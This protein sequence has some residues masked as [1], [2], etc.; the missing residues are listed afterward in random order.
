MTWSCG[1]GGTFGL[2]AVPLH[3]HSMHAH[4]RH[5]IIPGA[6]RIDARWASVGGSPFKRYVCRNAVLG[7]DVIHALFQTAHFAQVVGAF[8]L[9][10]A[11]VVA[12]EAT[13][14]VWAKAIARVALC[15][16]SKTAGGAHKQQSR[17][18]ETK[19]EFGGSH[20][21]PALHPFKTTR[22]FVTENEPGTPRARMLATFLSVS[23]ST[24]PSSVTLPFFTIMR[25][26]LITGMSYFCREGY[27]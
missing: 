9:E 12:V 23:L 11:R 18:E 20:C 1:G 26:G 10:P 7:I 15:G 8:V 14:V 27:P 6:P 4:G 25:I 21:S 3:Q 19:S 5:A 24:T 13:L 17:Q 16:L 22:L 2:V